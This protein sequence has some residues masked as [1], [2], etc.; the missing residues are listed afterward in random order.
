M[1][2]EIELW[3]TCV[4]LGQNSHSLSYCYRT[5]AVRFG[6]EVFAHQ[7]IFESFVMSVT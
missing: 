7:K 6:Y 4:V 1:C 3:G 5:D 2:Y